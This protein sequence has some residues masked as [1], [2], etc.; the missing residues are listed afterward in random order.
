[1]KAAYLDCFSGVAGNMAL[2]A[3]I[4]AGAS[5]RWIR[6][7]MK[8]LGL[9]FRLVI[10]DRTS[11]HMSGCHVRVQ[12][13]K[14]GQPRRGLPQIE[15][16]INKS[17]LPKPVREKSKAVFEGL[18]RAEARVHGIEPE[19]VH[20]HEVGAVD[21]IVDVVG[22]VAGLYRLGVEELTCS[23]L[24]LGG[25]EVECA[26]GTL[27]LPAPATLELLKGVPVRGAPGQDE[28]VTPTGAALVKTLA[29]SFG[30]MPAMKV[31]SVGIG[32]GDRETEGRPNLL[33]LITGEKL[34]S[35]DQVMQMEAAID[36]MPGEHFELLMEELHRAG[37]LEVLFIPAQMKKNRPGTLVRVLA[38]V[39]QKDL[40]RDALL[41]HSTTL[42][43]R[44]YPVYRTVLPR[45]SV[46]VR[47]DYG[48]VRI[49]KATRPQGTTI[50]HPE[51]EDLKRAAA[52]S[53]VD[54]HTVLRAAIA[55]AQE[56]GDKS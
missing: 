2:A 50:W 22:F 28:T 39:E 24:P 37:A 27:P 11:A 17:G 44:E 10:K 34:A 55:A 46:K 21:A 54:L 40:V 8:G 56:S 43:V 53:G 5:P 33:R 30:P 4:H 16:I 15:K 6:Q 1:M 45:E 14:K 23:P 19:Q 13:K 7:A 41:S 18:A 12:Y 26:H 35:G 49:K 47:T 38:G 32:L 25:G 52:K 36:D 3:A 51:Y 31:E 9:D 20:F 29:S 42:G 48:P